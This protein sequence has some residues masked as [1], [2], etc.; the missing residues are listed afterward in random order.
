[1]E[2]QVAEHVVE[3]PNVDFKKIHI[4]F[5]FCNG[6]WLKLTIQWLNQ[7]LWGVLSYLDM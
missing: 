6:T 3:V 2:F 5:V 1:M 7:N 4:K